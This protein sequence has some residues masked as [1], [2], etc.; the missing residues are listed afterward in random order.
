M[1]LCKICIKRGLREGEK[2]R[3]MKME[4]L[5]F[6]LVTKIMVLVFSPLLEAFIRALF[7]SLTTVFFLSLNSD[8]PPFFLVAVGCAS[9][10]KPS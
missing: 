2:K 9:L 3:E 6:S 8:P 1:S 4:N 10:F 7:T 5:L